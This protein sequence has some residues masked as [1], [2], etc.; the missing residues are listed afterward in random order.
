IDELRK[1]VKMI[2]CSNCGAPI[3]LAKT[4]TC[5]HCGSPLSMLDVN[6]AGALITELQAA[7]QASRTIDPAFPIR[8]ALARAQ[9]ETACA[10]FDTHPRWFHDVSENGLVAAGL[11]SMVRWLNQQL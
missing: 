10:G 9:A 8:L 5:A 1:N 6:R 4:T 7:D 2:N 3:D 11:Q